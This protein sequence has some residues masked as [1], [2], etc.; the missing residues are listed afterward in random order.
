MSAWPQVNLICHM[1]PDGRARAKYN[2]EAFKYNLRAGFL[3][4]ALSWCRAQAT[5]ISFERYT[6]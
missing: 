5:V 1:E 2:G 6:S 4:V 3:F